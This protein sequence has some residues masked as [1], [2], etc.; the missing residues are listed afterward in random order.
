MESRLEMST[1]YS[2]SKIENLTV[3]LIK[4]NLNKEM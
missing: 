1:I 2:E 4:K 3:K